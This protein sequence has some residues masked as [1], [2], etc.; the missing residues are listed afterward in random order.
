MLE[1]DE[2]PLAA[3][4]GLAIA[5]IGLLLEGHDVL[6]QGEFGRH[7]TNLARVTQETDPPQGDL[8]ERWAALATQIGRPA[9]H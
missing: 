3:A 8:L 2:T 7:L 1:T 5:L 9:P 4:T 6:P